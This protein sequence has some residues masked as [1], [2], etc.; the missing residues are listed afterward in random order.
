MMNPMPQFYRQFDH[1]VEDRF[2]I[3]AV[4]GRVAASRSARLMV[5]D[6]VGRKE[7]AVV[8]G[9]SLLNTA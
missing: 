5:D 2:G 7:D 3:I 1:M 8:P 4:Q 6:L 9:V